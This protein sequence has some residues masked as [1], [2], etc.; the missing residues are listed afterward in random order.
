VL[1]S[2]RPAGNGAGQSTPK[3]GSTDGAYGTHG[4]YGSRATNDPFDALYACPGQGFQH[5][6]SPITFHFSLLTPYPIGFVSTCG[7]SRCN[8]LIL[9]MAT[10]TSAS[11]NR[12][13]MATLAW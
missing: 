6:Q 8:S 7:S 12:A 3:A 10:C 4:T 13:L 1:W 9:W 11:V 5:D 2:P